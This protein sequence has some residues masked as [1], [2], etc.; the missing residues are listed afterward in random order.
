MQNTLKIQ[1][2]QD[3]QPASLWDFL[4]LLPSSFEAQILYGLLLA[5]ATGMVSNYTLK[6]A[7][8]E[9]EGSL[10]TY[11]FRCH[12]KA[13]LLSFSSFVGLAIT[14]IAADIFTGN[15]GGFV[16]WANV[17][18]FGLT[19]GFAVDAIAN[20]GQRVAWSDDKRVEKT[21]VHPTLKG[22]P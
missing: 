7:R 16:G 15:L 19:N 21:E 5:G 12:L 4:V 9:I 3:A 18:W 1:D 2:I 6:W 13:T 11:L 22:V 8:S 10:A 14:S 17:L 20:K